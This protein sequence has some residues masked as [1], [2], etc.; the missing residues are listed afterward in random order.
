M[1]SDRPLTCLFVVAYISVM[2]ALLVRAAAL[3]RPDA[4]EWSGVLL[5]V[6][7]Y[8]VA[9]S[10]ALS[11]RHRLA[12]AAFWLAGAAAALVIIF[13]FDGFNGTSIALVTAMA[14]A[15]LLAAGATRGILRLGTTPASNGATAYWQIS[16]IEILGW[17]IVVAVASAGLRFAD[18]GVLR[19]SYQNSLW[20]NGAIA[21][22]VAA[23]FLTP[24]RRLD[25]IAT[26][27]ASV[28][29]FG[30][31][32]L[33]PR[34]IDDWYISSGFLAPI[35]AVFGLWILV[36]RLDEASASRIVRATVEP[37]TTSP[38]EDQ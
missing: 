27:L 5:V 23:L 32:F 4:G 10:T 21:G 34:L 38:S 35:Y 17:M 7:I 22:A 3:D 13:G 18:F 12:R 33:L 14:A 37:S 30:A 25:R 6:G 16:I 15:P 31:F 20:I 24:E 8:I 11:Q 2:A 9:T 19:D 36:L 29:V 1:L 28:V 26:A